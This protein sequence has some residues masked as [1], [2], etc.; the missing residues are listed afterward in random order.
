M[1]NILSEILSEKEIVLADGATGTNLFNM[2][3]KAG[4]APELL[5]T[6]NP[7]TIRTLYES[8]VNAGSD[9]FLTNT[10]GANG[11]R[12]KLHNAQKRVHELNR[13]GAELG[14]DIVDQMGH[15]VIVAGS[16]GPTGELMKPLGDL[17]HSLAVE[18]VHEQV[19]SLQQ[20]GADISLLETISAQEEF[21]AAAE[22]FALANAPWVETMSFDTAGRTMMGLTPKDM[23]KMID[24]L[25]NRPTAY[26]ANCGVGSSDL[27]RTILSFKEHD[28]DSP[29]VAKGNAGIPKFICEN[30]VYDGTP[31]LMADYADLAR[32]A[33]ARII[34]G[35]C[36]T[37]QEHL[38][39]MRESIDTRPKGH[40]P[41]LEEI[42][43]KLGAFSSTSDTGKKE[44]AKTLSGRRKG[45][46][47]RT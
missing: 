33:G 15:K 27:L 46:K 6:S 14:R 4:D 22:A 5:N 13:V 24:N 34:G 29:L 9:L 19:D 45:R 47:R 42:A 43:A 2:G 35:C 1:N 17:T 36:G 7:K 12:L 21:L 23:I 16:V 18:I 32:N 10:F 8:A 37:G 26:G 38:K 30:I 11:A 41:S 20:G 3:L 31:D 25:A 44:T 39:K 40:P 28:N